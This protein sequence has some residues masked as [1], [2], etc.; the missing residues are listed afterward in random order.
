M[1]RDALPVP[2][3]TNITSA[4]LRVGLGMTEE[5][6]EAFRTV[7]RQTHRRHRLAASDG[8]PNVLTDAAASWNKIPAALQRA[9]VDDV[10]RQ[11]GRLRLFPAV[12]SME[13]VEATVKHRLAIVR[14]Q[15]RQSVGASQGQDQ[16]EAHL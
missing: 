10:I 12:L 6:F 1:L 14:R 16:N 11:C 8:S 4:E 15:W 3:R 2:T 9:M 7:A 5:A 13:V